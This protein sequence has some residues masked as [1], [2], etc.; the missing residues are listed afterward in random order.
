MADHDGASPPVF[1]LT[2]VGADGS[3]LPA[4][5][6]QQEPGEYLGAAVRMPDGLCVL[7]LSTAAPQRLSL[8]ALRAWLATTTPATPS[9]S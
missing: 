2:G 7:W 1:I 8:A 4:V 9:G 3:V 5:T 6:P